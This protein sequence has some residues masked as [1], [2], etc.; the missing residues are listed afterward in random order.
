MWYALLL[1]IC[2]IN[3]FQVIHANEDYLI[4]PE[5]VGVGNQ[6]SLRA[7]ALLDGYSLRAEGSE[8]P[9]FGL[10][11]NCFSLFA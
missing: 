1:R 11:H 8:N 6:P 10:K 4:I 9:A 3:R 5:G 2:S 7:S